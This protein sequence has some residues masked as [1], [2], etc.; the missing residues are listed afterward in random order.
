MKEMAS[1]EIKE[2]SQ[3][4]A[5]VSRNESIVFQL[6]FVEGFNQDCNLL[7]D[8]FG[9]GM[10]LVINHTEDGVGVVPGDLIQYQG[11]GSSELADIELVETI[12]A[13]TVPI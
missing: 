13:P 9:T 6:P 7:A 3:F 4:L 12:P 10:P 8:D 5:Q 11:A 1:K 2:F